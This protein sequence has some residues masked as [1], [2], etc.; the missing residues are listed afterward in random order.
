M[1]P[2]ESRKSNREARK[3]GCIENSKESI[4]HIG[5]IGHAGLRAADAE[6][7]RRRIAEAVGDYQRQ[8]G[9]R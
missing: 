9:R 1:C 7:R 5:H 3:E 2:K 4:G 8:N 6:S